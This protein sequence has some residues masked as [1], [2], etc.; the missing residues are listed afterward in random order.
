MNTFRA[1]NASLVLALAMSACADSPTDIKGEVPRGTIVFEQ[2][3]RA[4]VLEFHSTAPI[5]RV[6][7]GYGNLAVYQSPVGTKP[8]KVFVIGLSTI[9]SRL[10]AKVDLVG[11][12]EAEVRA[13][14]IQWTD[15][16]GQPHAAN[17]EFVIR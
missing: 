5:E 2:G 9:P 3:T 17:D 15:E 16:D 8:Y 13:T 4:A 14:L 12:L 11:D 1:L 7:L 10:P 6:V